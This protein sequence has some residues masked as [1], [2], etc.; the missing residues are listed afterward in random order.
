[1]K[2]GDISSAVIEYR[3]AVRDSPNSVAAR[4]ALAAA[5]ER[6][7]DFTGA[8]QQLRKAI[9]AGGSPD[10]LIPRIALIMLETG[11]AGKIVSE[12]KEKTLP[13]AKANSD[14]L[15]TVALASIATRRLTLAEH[16]LN[17]VVEQ[18][19]VVSLA[20]GQLLLTK[21]NV[22]EAVAELKK[23]LA[24]PSTEAPTAWWLPRALA[25][26][27]QATGNNEKALEYLQQAL[28]VAPWHIGITGEYGDALVSASRWKEASVIRDKLRSIAPGSLWLYLLD[29]ALLA[30]NGQLEASQASALKVLANIPEH[31]RAT[32]L[33]ASA[34][35]QLNQPVQAEERLRKIARTY[36]YSPPVLHLLATAQLRLGQL[37]DARSSI[38]RGLQVAPQ[39]TRFLSLKADTEILQGRIKDAT[40]T[41]E[42]LVSLAPG[43]VDS[44]LRL[45]QIKEK[46]GKRELAI[47]FME[48]AGELGKDDPSIR[49][50]IIA[51]S[52]RHGNPAVARQL[53]DYAIKTYPNDP[54]SHLALTATLAAQ[55]DTSG[56]WKATLTALDLKPDYQPALN[57]LASL[58]RN[59]GQHQELL[60]RYEKA[61]SAKPTDPLTYL[62]YVR[63][64]RGKRNAPSDD[65]AIL[66]KGVTQLPNV[67]LL[68]EA[69]INEN[70]AQGK[71][72]FAITIAQEGAAISGA[73]L[74]ALALL[75]T[76][77]ERLGRNEQATE[78]YRK[79]STDFPQL[80]EWRLR[81]ADIELRQGR[82]EGAK[83]ALQSLIK[84]LPKE[85]AAYVKLAHLAVEN[86][87]LSDALSIARQLGEN[88]I[89]RKL[90]MILKTVVG[91]CVMHDFRSDGVRA[92]AR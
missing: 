26:T 15:A 92:A 54:R 71:A 51:I 79:L 77:Y 57:A 13:N 47:Q 58:V 74:S 38:Q 62:E 63:L 25:R 80:V 31:L 17:L 6:S 14:L 33:V 2:K 5:L 70:I 61:V 60:A 36:S 11:N 19:P 23:G 50:R 1:M 86:N 52:L 68:R 85:P 37:T 87:N 90:A 39:D 24:I 35:L 40:Q 4:I 65:L 49:D 42:E 91:G 45:S 18:T 72:D 82:Q 75:A 64:L 88:E 32:L 12:F 81:F 44:Y 84:D 73:P 59:A 41:L 46:E 3:N 8:E 29:S 30:E 69:L 67:P 76:T 27:Y 20:K 22:S 66:Q 55:N 7:N 16:Q 78:A 21:G 56:A 83:K 28:E 10:E 89:N 43:H 48:K 9:E 34:E 53:A